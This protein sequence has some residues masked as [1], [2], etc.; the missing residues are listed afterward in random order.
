[1]NLENE[2]SMSKFIYMYN[3]YDMEIRFS[4]IFIS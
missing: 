3:A 1:M 4:S 2:F